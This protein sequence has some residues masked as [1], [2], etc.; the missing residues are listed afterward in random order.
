M[1]IT[2]E[3]IDGCGKSTQIR[4]LQQRLTDCGLQV[5]LTREP[6]GSDLGVR[7]RSM[8][9]QQR[10]VNLTPLSELFLYLADR[11]QHV[12]EVI[13][14]ALAR[15]EVVLCDRFADS[16]VAYQG[17][18][19]GLDTQLLD[20]L[21]QMAIAGCVPDLTLILDLPVETGLQRARARN[22]RDKQS[23]SE[24]RFEA[25]SLAFHQRIREGYLLLA[26]LHPKRC[27]VVQADRD[28]ENVCEQIWSLVTTRLGSMTVAG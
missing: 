15:G 16:T 9:L 5:T 17:Y 3:G 21:N 27:V 4:L 24:D 18:G 22:D 8:L 14:P 23:R 1:F 2:F 13:K 20:S 19:R 11:A 12:A 6:G 28:L 7:L 25:E 26:A 10:S